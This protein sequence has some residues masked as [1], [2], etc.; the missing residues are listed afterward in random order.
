[1]I[2][3]FL[4]L[5]CGSKAS[6]PPA[7]P[8][9]ANLPNIVLVT[10]DTT[11]ADAMGSYGGQEGISPHFDAIAKAGIQFDAAFSHSPTTLSAHSS[12]FTGLD[13]HGHAVPRNGFPLGD[14]FETLAERLQSQGYDTLGIV[15]ASVLNKEMGIAQG[16]RLFDEDTPTDMGRRFEDRADRVTRRALDLVSQRDSSRPFFLWVHYY[17]AHSPY[18]APKDFRARFTKTEKGS[19]TSLP[20]SDGR[21]DLVMNLKDWIGTETNL[22]YLKGLYF[23]E[24]AW[25]DRQMGRLFSALEAQGLLT[26]SLVAITADHGEAFAD[27]RL[28]PVGHGHD[29]D[30]WATRIPMVI[31]GTGTFATTGMHIDQTVKSSDLGATL[32]S[33]AG[34]EASFGQGQNLH[35]LIR[36]ETLVSNPVFMEASKPKNSETEGLWNNIGHEQG[37][38]DGKFLYI[39]NTR[40]RP[41]D[42]LFS[43]ENGGQKRLDDPA[44]LKRLREAWIT[45]NER[46]PP[47][48][49]EAFSKEMEDALRALGYLE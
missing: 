34:L 39:N 10:L 8:V 6:E 3:L 41:A 1:M 32:L 9:K 2:V 25:V 47:Y 33:M 30:S 13:P 46:A 15:A 28:H 19:K 23:A 42:Q 49:T 24:I 4:I 44:T 26:N 43:L 36:G 48:R 16:F 12:I 17:D 45:W 29:V 7:M 22:A 37:V 14:A 5:A 21:W 38:V 31:R 40:M 35:R 18:N 20:S 11:R 27:G